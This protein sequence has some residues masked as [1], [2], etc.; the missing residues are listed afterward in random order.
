MISYKVFLE[1]Y[2]DEDTSYYENEEENINPEDH[3]YEEIR[4]Y[5]SMHV[6]AANQLNRVTI[7]ERSDDFA[8]EMHN[9]VPLATSSFAS[10][11]DATLDEH[12]QSFIEIEDPLDTSTISLNTKVFKWLEDNM[13]IS[14]VEN[15]LE[16]NSNGVDTCSDNSTIEKEYQRSEESLLGLDATS[17]VNTISTTHSRIATYKV[18]VLICVLVTLILS[19]VVI[20]IIMINIRELF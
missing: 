20:L 3:I 5:S 4:H 13:R 14:S 17:H 7:E 18:D 15:T 8:L 10:M 1:Q 9:F 19:C 16:R 12:E 11:N 6:Q 2:I